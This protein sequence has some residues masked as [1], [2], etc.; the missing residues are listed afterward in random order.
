MNV[1]QALAAR[2][3]IRAFLSKP[4]EQEKLTAIFEAAA[5]TPSWANTQ[6]WES[7]VASGETLQRIKDG[8]RENYANGVAVVAE[9]P[10]PIIAD[11][12]EASSRR[13]KQLHP[14]ME[15]DCGEAAREFGKLN[16]TLF[17]APAV[18]Y[19]CMDRKH[20][21]WSLYDIGAYAQS[22][23]LAAVE[24]GLGTMPAIQL[25][26]FPALLH[27]ELQI[28]E[29]MQI[30]IG[31]A[32]GYPDEEHGINLFRSERDSVEETVHFFG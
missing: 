1:T 15:R 14:G 31:I 16:Q 25:T 28:P 32:V 9:T 10:R 24:Q 4:V 17:H 7:F 30:T 11:W 29:S 23:M 8:F 27:E 22:L 26:N 6:P 13:R 2:R 18:I 3:S 21:Q 20:S 19:I 5:R 12:S